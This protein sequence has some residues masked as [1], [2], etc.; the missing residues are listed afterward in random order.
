[1]VG[2]YDDKAHTYTFELRQSCAATPNQPV[3]DP[4]VLP[5]TVGLVGTDGSALPLAMVGDAD[6]SAAHISRTL[7]L[8]T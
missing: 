8:Q 1:M 2:E 6:A 4:F 5:V 3:K 7:V